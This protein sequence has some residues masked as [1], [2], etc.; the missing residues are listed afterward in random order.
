MSRFKDDRRGGDLWKL[1]GAR[2]AVVTLMGSL[3]W[4]MNKLF[5]E[6]NLTSPGLPM[7]HLSFAVW[8]AMACVAV[9]YG[10]LR[11]LVGARK[12]DL[13]ASQALA[14]IVGTSRPGR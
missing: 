10:I 1:W 2:I 3:V 7:K 6:S 5:P 11:F 4:L 14:W 8:A 13:M 12:F 9:F